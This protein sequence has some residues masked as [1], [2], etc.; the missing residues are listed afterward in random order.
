MLLRPAM[1]AAIIMAAAAPAL[2]ER[3]LSADDYLDKLRGMWLGEIL[4]NYAGRPY[5]GA[6]ATRGGVPIETLDW[7]F[8]ST[9]PWVGDDDT[10]F[11]YM[12]VDLLARCPAPSPSQTRS[13]WEEH[14]PL[15]SFYIANRQARWLMAGNLTPPAT[16]SIQKNMHWYAIDAQ[17]TTESVGASAPGMRLVAADI[18][19]RLGSVTNDGYALHA[20]QFY[21]AMYAA[22]PLESDVEAVVAK[23]LEVVPTTSRTHALIQDVRDWYA[24]DKTDGALDWRSTQEKI[25]DKY[26]G[27]AAMGR[28][29]NWV[30]SSVNTALTTMAILYGQG[31]FKRTVEIGVEGGFDC[32]CNPATAGGLVGLMRGWSGL[33]PSLTAAATDNY[34]ILTLVNY[35]PATTL[36]Q[37]ALAQRAVAEQQIRLAGG[38]IEGEGPARLYRLPADIVTPPPEK[39]DPTGPRGLVAAVRAAGGAV[40]VSASVEKRNPASDR[41]NLDGI[42]DGITDVSYN[43]RLPYTTDDGANP[44]PAGGDFYQLNF[45]RQAVFTSLVFDEGDILWNGVNAN[46]REVEPKG[47]YF[48]WATVEVGNGGVFTPVTSLRQSE[49]LDPYTYFQRIEYTFGPAVGNAI[50]LRGEAGGTQE[51]TSIVELEAD[52]QLLEPGTLLWTG[53]IDNRWTIG[54]AANWSTGGA[55]QGYAEGGPV[56]FDDRGAYA[57]P[58]DITT[59]V[60]PA[61]VLVYNE[62]A[63][64]VLGGRGSIAGPCGLTKNGKGALTLA[65]SN[66]YTGLTRVNAGTLIVAAE[67]ALG[68]SAVKLGDTSGS[69]DASLLVADAYTVDRPITV[70]D[71][72][73][74]TSRRTLG[75]TNTAGPAVFSGDLTIEKDLTLTAERGG[76][77]ILSGLLD[78][79]EGHTFTK[80]GA[81]I[82]IFDG[83]QAHGPGALLDVDAGTVYLDTDAGSAAAANLSIDVTNAV[84]SFGCNQHLDTLN[85]GDGGEVVFAGAR[86][87]MLQ[88]LVMGGIDF[89]ATTLTPE[90]ATLALLGLGIAGV[91][92]RRRV[93]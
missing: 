8:I 51:F 87:V 44:Q 46:P 57:L 2:A 40:T 32:D 77:V 18:A 85:I 64:V 50:R 41:D 4:G 83:F 92:C 6:Y 55:A 45:D 66:T 20:A 56:V 36:T 76:A 62:A 24:A 43:G 26:V 89:G 29:H 78:N 35:P 48:E 86:V 88:H 3:T 69:R 1:L 33:P 42:I 13:I 80:I 65:T 10:V 81:G 73:S 31:D 16:G 34:S 72:G 27:P 58:I 53:G 47:G 93:R 52:G 70:Q 84:V 37:I 60:H 9:N 59:T 12:Y 30:E 25:Y 49:A 5:E 7:S 71:D 17:I 91:L 19:G 23:G 14:V 67:S 79:S 75:G 74:P 11:E 61:S 82:V 39:P 54:Q 15:P 63:N 28:Y 68:A 21:A 90:P 38:A 22:A